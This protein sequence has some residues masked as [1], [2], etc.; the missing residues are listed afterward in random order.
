MVTAAK[1]IIKGG[2][3][4]NTLTMERA[5]TLCKMGKGAETCSFLGME[6]GV[7]FACQKG[8]EIEGLIRSRRKAGTMSAKGDNCSGPPDFTPNPA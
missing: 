4:D 7:G 6:A 2:H 8:T 3:M 1:P 5:R